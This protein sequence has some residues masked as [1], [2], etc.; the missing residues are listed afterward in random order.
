M[1]QRSKRA[2]Q[3]CVI[4]GIVTFDKM[5]TNNL[6]I[7]RKALVKSLPPRSVLYATMLGDSQHW[8]AQWWWKICRIDCSW[9]V[10]EGGGR[11]IRACGDVVLIW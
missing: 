3:S 5:K 6:L 2:P 9:W 11:N 4:P 7:A 8:A 10:L 1:F